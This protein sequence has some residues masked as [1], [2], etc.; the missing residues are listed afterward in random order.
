MAETGERP[1]PHPGFRFAV[2]I[3]GIDGVIFNE[4]TLP[5][6]EID[7][8]TVK[9]GGYNMGV[10]QLPGQVKT[11]RLVLKRGMVEFEQTAGLV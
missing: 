2:Q 11:G 4:C 7:L 3:E 5:N 8:I 1:E 6:L 9:E 10:R